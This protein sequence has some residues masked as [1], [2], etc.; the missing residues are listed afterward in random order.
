MRSSG[1]ADLDA[2]VM[3]LMTRAS[4]VPAPPPGANRTITVPIN[5]NLK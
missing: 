1:F 3:A 4:P 2:E 5:F